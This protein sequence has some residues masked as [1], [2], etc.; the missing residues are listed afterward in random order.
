MRRSSPDRY[1]RIAELRW[2]APTLANSSPFGIWLRLAYIGRDFTR[3][4]TEDFDPTYMRPLFEYGRAQIK[5]GTAWKKSS[6]FL[7]PGQL[8]AGKRGE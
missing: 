4:H 2:I 7:I 3:E 6:P 5:D 1:S 8:Q